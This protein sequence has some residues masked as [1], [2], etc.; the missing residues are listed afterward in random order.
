MR[1]RRTPLL[2]LQ[3][4]SVLLQPSPCLAADS[5]LSVE[6]VV[7]M[8]RF[9]NGSTLNLSADGEW[10]A[11]TIDDGRKKRA[12]GAPNEIVGF[13]GSYVLVTRI[14]T[15]DTKRMTDEQSSS[16]G[17]VWSLDGLRLAYYS[18]HSGS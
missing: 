10:V 16:W 8:Q 7:S 17:P 13:S 18:N 9:L 1:L 12:S 2:V 3:V 6:D 15:G 4:C 14:K 11:Y 5:A